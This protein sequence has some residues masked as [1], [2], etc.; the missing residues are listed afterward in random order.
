MDVE[1]V[2]EG[3][4]LA[5]GQ[6]RL[7]ALFVEGGLLFVVDEDHDE[8][9]GLG[10]LGAGHHLHALGLS[11]GPALGALVQAHN[12]VHAAL[13]QVQRVSVALRAVADDGHSLARQFLKIA[14]LLIED[15]CHD[16]LPLF[17]Y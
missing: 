8:V 3:Q 1:A 7:D 5:L 12:N 15:P 14:V 10:G 4:G 13:F 16:V 17:F 2:G 11:L 9:G 6:I